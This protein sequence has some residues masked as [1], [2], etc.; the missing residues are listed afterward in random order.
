MLSQRSFCLLSDLGRGAGIQQPLRVPLHYPD[1][2]VG[3][4]VSRGII[5]QM[6]ICFQHPL[7]TLLPAGQRYR[8]CLPCPDEI[9]SDSAPFETSAA[10]EVGGYPIVGGTGR[11]RKTTVTGSH[12][13]MMDLVRG[14]GALC[15]AELLWPVNKVSD[16]YFFRTRHY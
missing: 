13:L 11:I 8:R 6:I 10:V 7:Y 9:V 12:P 2:H 4:P 3:I 16:V 15:L 14:G 1:L 5:A